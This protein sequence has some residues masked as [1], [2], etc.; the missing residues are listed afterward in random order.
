MYLRFGSAASSD[1][2]DCAVGRYI[3][4][5]GSVG[6]YCLLCNGGGTNQ[7]G[8]GMYQP[9]AGASSCISCS[10]GLWQDNSGAETCKEMDGC[11]GLGPSYVKP[12]TVREDADEDETVCIDIPSPAIGNNCSCEEDWKVR[13]RKTLKPQN[14]K[15]LKP[16]PKPKRLLQQRQKLLSG[17]GVDFA[18]RTGRVCSRQRWHVP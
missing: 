4:M 5:T 1:C 16:K 6:N 8:G 9:A 2:I 15:T 12:C 3:N 10:A 14:R 13:P 17:L 18:W 7:D 11:D